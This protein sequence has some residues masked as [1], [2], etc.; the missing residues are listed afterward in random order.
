MSEYLDNKQLFS[1]PKV[2]QYNN[3]MVMTNVVKPEKKKYIFFDTKFCD[4]NH[5]SNQLSSDYNFTLSDRLTDVKT[6]SVVNAEVPMSF[7]NISNSLGN[8]YFQVTTDSSNIMVIIPDGQY[9][10]ATLSTAINNQLINFVSS[11]NKVTYGSFVANNTSFF[12]ASPGGRFTINFAVDKTGNFDK[13]NLK[14]KLGWLL[15]FRNITYI[16][17]GT[18]ISDLT[19]SSSIPTTHLEKCVI[20]EAVIN[21]YPIRYLFLA[22]DELCN[23]N[24]ESFISLL[25]KSRINKNIIAKI[26]IDSNFYPYGTILN[27]NIHTGLLTSDTRTYT[28]NKVDIQKLNIQLLDDRG[29]PINLNGLDFSFG[30][31]IDYE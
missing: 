16:V 14:S 15:G 20:S 6:I 4:E 24:Q 31:K 12:Y 3:H 26:C 5:R 9:T 10:I 19:L 2:G 25:P 18:A 30:V 13:F 11:S 1:S 21:M 8:N 23:G 28:G 22:V 27:V 7:Y 29:N 17:N